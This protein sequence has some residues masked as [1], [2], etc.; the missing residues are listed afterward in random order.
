MVKKTIKLWDYIMKT[1]VFEISVHLDLIPKN[2]KRPP[3]EMVKEDYGV[4]ILDYI[5][6][7]IADVIFMK[8]NKQIEHLPEYIEY[9]KGRF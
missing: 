1:E 5:S 7:P 9:V 6:M 4:L 2:E 3:F 8:I